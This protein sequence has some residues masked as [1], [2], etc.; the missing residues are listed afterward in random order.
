VNSELKV[1]VSG[2]SGAGKSLA[3]R[4][5]KEALELNNYEVLVYD[6]SKPQKESIKIRKKSES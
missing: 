3:L 2:L 1:T 5:I 4:I 6:Y